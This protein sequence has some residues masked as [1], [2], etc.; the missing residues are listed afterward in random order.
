MA[1]AVGM[2]VFHALDQL[3]VTAAAPWGTAVIPVHTVTAAASQDL[4]DVKV[5]T[6][7]RTERVEVS[8]GTYA[9][10]HNGAI[11]A[12]PLDSVATEPAFVAAAVTAPLER[13]ELQRQLQMG[14][15]VVPMGTIASVLRKATAAAIPDFAAT[16][17][18]SAE[19]AVSPPLAHVQTPTSRRTA[20]AVDQPGTIAS[21]SLRAIAVVGPDSAAAMRPIAALGARASS[22]IAL[23]RPQAPELLQHHPLQAMFPRTVLA[24]PTGGRVWVRCSEAAVVLKTT[25]VPRSNIVHKDGKCLHL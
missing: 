6:S 13:V 3:T 10:A 5:A 8:T 4:E 17:Q 15:V 20:P 14:H 21:D 25:A 23:I 19:R 16:R 18:I 12:V 2:L 1:P 24:A 22:E 11:A 7:R 9:R